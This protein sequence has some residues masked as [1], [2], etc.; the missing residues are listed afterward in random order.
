MIKKMNIW[1]KLLTVMEIIM[2]NKTKEQ[3]IAA[4]KRIFDLFEEGYLPYL[5]HFCGGNEDQLIDIFK[6]ISEG[7]YVLS[8]HRSHYHYLL[9]G[10]SEKSLEEKILKGDSMFIFDKKINFLTSSIL[11]GTTSIACGVAFA[12]KEKGQ[13]QKVWCFIGDGAEEEGHFYEAVRYV[14]G[15][16]LPCTFIIEDNDR[17]DGTNKEQ[18]RGKSNFIWPGCVIKYEYK[19]TF[20]HAGTGTGKI[21]KEF[22]K[23]V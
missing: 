1:M 14:D 20:P 15:W 10:G 2:F 3:L 7:D 11:A 16:N 21:I 5:V 6:N 8:T 22:K 9:A 19:S 23:I 13:N 12:I 18:R 17:S 4:E